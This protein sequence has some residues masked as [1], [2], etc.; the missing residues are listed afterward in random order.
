MFV[1]GPKAI[2]ALIT[3]NPYN[4]GSYT[5]ESYEHKYQ[6]AISVGHSKA[7][8]ITTFMGEFSRHHKATYR[9]TKSP[10]SHGH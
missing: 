4:K 6:L 9:G 7:L 10:E 8:T 1:T 2:E 3:V 5:S